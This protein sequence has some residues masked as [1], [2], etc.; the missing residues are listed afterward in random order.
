MSSILAMSYTAF[1]YIPSASH[2]VN[3]NLVFLKGRRKKGRNEKREVG[4]NEGR[5]ERSEDD[6]NLE[7][8]PTTS[9]PTT[10]TQALRK[11]GEV[12]GIMTET[13]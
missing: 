10:D 5:E 9:L 3:K 8:P 11:Q 7:L 6:K 13:G 4:R 1:Y 2:I 12:P